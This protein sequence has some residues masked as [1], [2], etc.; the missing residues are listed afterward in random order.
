MIQTL[1][2]HKRD[3]GAALPLA[4]AAVA[5][6][7]GPEF[8][9]FP[10][11]IC[12]REDVIFSYLHRDPL[13]YAS[14]IEEAVNYMQGEIAPDCPCLHCLQEIRTAYPLAAGRWDE[15]EQA[16]LEAVKLAWPASDYHHVL[17]AFTSLCQVAFQRR[18]WPKLAH[19]S[20]MGK[21]F[22]G[23]GVGTPYVHEL[24]MWQ[25]ASTRRVGDTHAAWEQYRQVRGRTRGLAST[26]TAGYFDALFAYQ[27]AD[28]DPRLALAVCDLELVGLAGR[29]EVMRECRVR[30]RRRHLLA[31]RGKST[32]DE[33]K[34]VR[35]LAQTLA[36]PQPVLAALENL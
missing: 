3:P 6:T 21:I 18:D 20:G 28:P 32:A 5:A 11:R 13:G 12:L 35:A 8:A 1:L 34:A 33:E 27:E 23:R 16:A 7:G 4:E 9:G 10:Q 25:A 22:D 14:E 19:W 31:L 36:D 26:P 30:L 24:L 17:I 29:G 2:F 15:A